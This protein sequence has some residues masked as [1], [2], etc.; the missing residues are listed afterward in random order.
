MKLV[1]IHALK[2]HEKTRPKRIRE[3]CAELMRQNAVHAIVVD[4][5]T[6]TVLDG[7]HRLHVLKTM[8]ARKIPVRMVALRSKAVSVR[9]RRKNVRVSKASVVSRAKKGTLYPPKTTKHLWKK[10]H[11]SILT[12]RTTIPLNELM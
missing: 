1:P 7:H 11:V 3:V 4:Q 2:P 10:K 5:K 8:G 6:R 12:K 9:S